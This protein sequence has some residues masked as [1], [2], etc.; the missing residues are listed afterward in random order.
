MIWGAIDSHSKHSHLAN[1]CDG[2]FYTFFKLRIITSK[3][4]E[5]KSRLHP[6]FFLSNLIEFNG[7]IILDFALLPWSVHQLLDAKFTSEN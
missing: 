7:D 2:D 5:W 6:V 3:K 4:F 1:K